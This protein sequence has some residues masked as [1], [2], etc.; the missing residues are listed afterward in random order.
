MEGKGGLLGRQLDASVLPQIDFYKGI[1]GS[2]Q[3]LYCLIGGDVTG[4]DTRLPMIEFDL[5]AKVEEEMNLIT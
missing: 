2:I 4:I 5:V 3:F 1:N